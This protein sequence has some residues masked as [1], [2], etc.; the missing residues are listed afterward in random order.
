MNPFIITDGLTY[1][2]EDAQL[3]ESP[4]LNDLSVE[5]KSGEFVAVLGHNGSGKS[6][7]AKLLNMILVPSGGKIYISGKDIT[8]ENMTDDDILSLRKNVGMVF[9]N[10]DN[11][12]V[13][14]MVEDDVAFGPE[15]LGVASEEIR[16]RVD[17]ALSDVGML[18][19][20]HHEPHRLSGGQ[21]QRVAIAGIM[22]MQPSC[23][24][25]DESTAM[26]DPMG[27]KEVMNSILRLNK[28]KNITVIMITHYMEEAAMAD[29]IIVLDDGNKLIEGTPAAVFEHD[30]ELRACGLNVPQCTELI[31]KLRSEGL[32]GAGDCVT[33]DQCADIIMA[34]IEKGTING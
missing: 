13:A 28:E 12:L 34:A 32:V 5:I 30:D 16:K 33:L 27:R 29:R 10:P 9:Q 21:K 14:T 2:Y 20:A 18:E 3:N 23:I 22:A 17:E 31:H 11:Q 24:I 25:F 8:D 15:N 1:R 26:L 19:Y 6:T 4:V 7:L